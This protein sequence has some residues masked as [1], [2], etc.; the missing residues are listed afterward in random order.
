MQIVA[1]T[2]CQENLACDIYQKAEEEKIMYRIL[3]DMG[4]Q[5]Y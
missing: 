4:F 1:V 3:L 5:F 2:I